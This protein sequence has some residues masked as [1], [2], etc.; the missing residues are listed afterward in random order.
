MLRVDLILVFD[1]VVNGSLEWGAIL[2]DLRYSA[3]LW[4][5]CGVAV[6]GCQVLCGS[7]LCSSHSSSCT[8]T[9][10][11]QQGNTSVGSLYKVSLEKLYKDQACSTRL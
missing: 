3:A 5:L 11:K 1:T 8:G 6:P 2:M 9:E 10:G 4:L 7:G